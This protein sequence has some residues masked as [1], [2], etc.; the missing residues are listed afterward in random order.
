MTE[1]RDLDFALDAAAVAT[2]DLDAARRVLLDRLSRHSNDFAAT[3]ALQA[4]NTY[5]AEQHAGAPTDARVR[6]AGLSG[7]DRLR[8]SH[9]GGSS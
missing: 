1:R 9:V 2:D 4:L 5:A 6:T 7:V 3:A 8:R